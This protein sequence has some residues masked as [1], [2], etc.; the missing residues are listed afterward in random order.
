MVP[1][2][3]FDTSSF[4]KK[5]DFFL[6]CQFNVSPFFSFWPI[7]SNEV[8]IIDIHALES[9]EKKTKK[10]FKFGLVVVS[11]ALTAFSP[12]KKTVF[13]YFFLI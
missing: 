8:D 10:I 12:S 3:L 4:W 6:C 13:I 1:L 9:N 11:M 5:G 7:D 2:Y